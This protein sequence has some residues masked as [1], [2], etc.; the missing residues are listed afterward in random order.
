MVLLASMV[1]VGCQGG[2]DSTTAMDGIADTGGTD[3]TGG[4]TG[5]ATTDDPKSETAETGGFVPDVS[6]SAEPVCDPWAQDCPDGEKCVFYANDGGSAPNA[7]KCVPITGDGV[8]GDPCSWGGIVEGTDNCGA[9]SVCWDVMDVDGEFV[10]VCTSFCGGTKEEPLCPP[11][12]SCNILNDGVINLCL[13]TCD[14]LI[15][16]CAGVGMACYWANVDF[17]CLATTEAHPT[18]EPCGF[19]N[20]CIAGNVCLPPESFPACAGASCCGQFCDLAN[21]EV[22]CEPAGT[23]C[24]TFFE[25]GMA[26]P[27]YEDVGVCVLP[28]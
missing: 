26:P 20:D 27:G 10:G 5:D 3:G 22:I 12:T 11:S 8:A 9:D 15:Q 17:N 7:N 14:P 25:E 23:E 2:K 28:M 6:G 21:P 1:V 13:A 4:T 19:I 24:V 18:G 16:D